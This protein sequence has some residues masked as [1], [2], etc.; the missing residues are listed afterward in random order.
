M[1]VLLTALTLALHRSLLAQ[2]YTAAQSH[3]LIHAIGW[4]IYDRMA[5]PPWELARAITA[6]PT[7][8]LRIAT[9]MFR[10]FPFGPPGY[11]WR[12]IDAGDGVVAFDCTK[13]PVAEFFAR[14]DT[15]DLCTATWCALDF[16]VAEKWGGRLVRPRTIA[17]GYD[18]CDFRWH[19]APVPENGKA[20]KADRG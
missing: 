9:G 12:D 4:D 6:D 11:G 2:D 19:S 7:K 17:D 5:D 14:H 18:H 8:R 16:P 1:A 3:A 10:R 20:R 15:A 13:C